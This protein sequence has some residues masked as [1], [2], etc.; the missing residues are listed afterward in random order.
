MNLEV[1]RHIFQN[2]SNI[3]F[4]ETPPSRGRVV[5]YGQ[6]DIC[7]KAIVALHNSAKAPNVNEANVC[8]KLTLKGR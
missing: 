4:H 8:N 6:R 5:P 3:K 7:D 2:Y 1:T